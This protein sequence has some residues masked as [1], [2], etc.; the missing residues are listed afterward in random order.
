[1]S[2]ADFR[3][4]APEDTFRWA[5]DVFAFGTILFEILAG[6]PAFPESLNQL[7]VAFPDSLLCSAL[8]LITDCWKA[9]PGDRPTFEEIVGRLAEMEWKVTANVASVKVAKFVSSNCIFGLKF[10]G[11]P[12]TNRAL[13]HKVKI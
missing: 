2:S 3:Y 6:G 1:M 9:A 4:L 10:C 5:S 8:E 11:S 7:Q 13:P 12:I